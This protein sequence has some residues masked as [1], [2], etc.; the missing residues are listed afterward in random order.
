MPF[1]SANHDITDK[2]GCEDLASFRRAF[3]IWLVWVYRVPIPEYMSTMADSSDRDI[4][5]R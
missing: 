1:S 2:D 3:G 4:D 5:M